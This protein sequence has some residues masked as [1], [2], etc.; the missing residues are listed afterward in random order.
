MADEKNDSEDAKASSPKDAESSAS[1][2][3]EKKE[4]TIK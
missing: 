3:V 1:T 4:S 2:K